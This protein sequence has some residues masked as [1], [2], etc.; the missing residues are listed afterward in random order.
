MINNVDGHVPALCDLFFFCLLFFLPC[1]VVF[2]IVTDRANVSHS[3]L[4]ARGV[5]AGDVVKVVD[6]DRHTCN[7][8]LQSACVFFY[9]HVSNCYIIIFLRPVMRYQASGCPRVISYQK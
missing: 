8:T 1:G 2:L 4:L 5:R 9:F 7:C 3:H 6:I